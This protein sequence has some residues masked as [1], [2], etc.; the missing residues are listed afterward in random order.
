MIFKNQMVSGEF[1]ILLHIVLN[2]S[3]K[4]PVEKKYWQFTRADLDN[5]MGQIME[6]LNKNFLEFSEHF[7]NIFSY[8][9]TTGVKEPHKWYYKSEN[10]ES[11]GK[12]IAV[13]LC[14]R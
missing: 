8:F 6:Y 10:R 11:D 13:L 4:G 5:F 9:P 2:N 3:E 7:M 14:D 1:S 12:N